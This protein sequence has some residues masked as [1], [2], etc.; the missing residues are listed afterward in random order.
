MAGPG[1]SVAAPT[2]T[3]AGLNVQGYALPDGRALLYGTVPPE[4]RGVAF[5][6]G[7][8]R[9]EVLT[10]NGGF[11]AALASGDLVDEIVLDLPAGPRRCPLDRRSHNYGCG[12][13]TSVVGSSASS[14][15]PGSSSSA[16]TSTVP[17]ATTAR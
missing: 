8:R 15:S 1:G 13:M 10:V 5:V 3:P 12:G 11:A 16:V 17:P 2:P 6:I 4:T 14:S 7:G 9:V